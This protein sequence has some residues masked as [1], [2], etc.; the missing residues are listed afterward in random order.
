MKSLE[1]RPLRLF[2]FLK[3]RNKMKTL[4][5]IFSI[6][7]LTTTSLLA[8]N[9]TLKGKIVDKTT[10]EPIIGAIIN[11]ENTSKGA[12]SDF[13]GNYVIAIDPGKYTV[14]ISYIS[15]QT[16]VIKEVEIK[17]NASRTLDVLL[18]EDTK[19]LGEFVVKADALKNTDATL[20]S[21]QKS[22]VAMMDG[23]SSQQIAAT[24]VSNAAETIKQSTGA[25]VEDGKYVVM[26]GL[27]DRYSISQINGIT[28]PGT[29]PYRN[30]SSMDLIPS[31]I[32]D[33]V[34]TLK[35]FT[36]D[37]PGNFSGGLIDVTTKSIP[38]KFILNFTI[39]TAINTQSSF[40]SNFLSDDRSATDF[41][42]I[43]NGAHSMPKY[44]EDA[45]T[46]DQLL[47]GLYLKARNPNDANDASRQLFHETSQSLGNKFVPNKKMVP[48]DHGFN[49]TIGN[50]HTFGKDAKNAFGYVVGLNYNRTYRHYDNGI[51]NTNINTGSQLFQYQGL[52]ENKSV[53]SPEMG[54]FASFGFKF[55]GSNQINLRY[56]YNNNSDYTARQQTG[57]YLGQISNSEAIFNTNVMEFTQRDLHSAELSGNHILEKKSGIELNWSGS[58]NRSTQ[59]E[60]NMRY[61]AYSYTVD[62]NFTDVKH[63]EL[64][65]VLDTSYAINNAEYSAPAHFYRHLTDQQAQGKVDLTIPFLKSKNRANAIKVG[66]LYSYLHRN[67]EEYRYAISSTGVPSSLAFSN[68]R[69]DM[70]AFFDS[71]NF[72][73]I[74]TL[75]NPDGSVQRYVTGYNYINQVRDFNFYSGTQQIAAAYAMVNYNIWLFKINA[76]VRME[77]TNMHV[78][79]R[80][81]SLAP[82]IVKQTDFLP[83]VNLTFTINET[84]NLRA[85]V[86]QTVARPNL[87]EMAPFYQFDPKNGFFNIGN[88]DLKRTLVTNYDLRYEWFPAVGDLI[89]VGGFYKSF[90]DPIIRA[91]NPQAS[92]PESRFINAN[93]AQVAGAELEIRKNLGFI[94]SKLKNFTFTFNAAYIWSKVDMEAQEIASAQVID[95]EYNQRYRPFQGQAP[96]VFNVIMTYLNEK[97]DMDASVSF[98]ISGKQLYSNGLYA[99]PDVYQEAVPMLNFR[100]A[101]RFKQHYQ[102]AFTA[103]NLVNPYITK[104]QDYKGTRN[105]VEQFKYGQTFGLSF[106]YFIK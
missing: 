96:Y 12:A 87:R 81:T 102:I 103:Q 6:F 68:F 94:W 11:I 65:Y 61:F 89:S 3:K 47:A 1:V 78:A 7:I 95:P 17:A 39:K 71:K 69:G 91:F 99:T 21:M 72:G 46:R 26:R 49:F 37:R 56:L 86:S 74:D 64:G 58:Y 100:I 42:G 48:M 27:G 4:T 60:P 63:P 10:G 40:N 98:N 85:A 44:L 33:N 83:A 97:I 66:G 34:V 77:N 20:V 31:S 105:I 41:L 5:T 57:K 24:G 73:I 14:K 23:V 62:T 45:S 8:Q 104:V 38:E 93:K 9:G 36:A 82:G 53:E 18:Q 2:F 80:D 13:D 28:M 50:R 16:Q 106:S 22:S 92:L 54:A 88:P 84:M 51:V 59:A 101:K 43:N 67:F 30:S 19:S 70:D 32:I 25:T 29:D 55:N 52:R 75:Y 35:T 15:Y 76:G 90:Q 79:S